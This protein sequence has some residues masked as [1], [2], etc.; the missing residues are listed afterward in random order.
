MNLLISIIIPTYN[1]KDELENTIK[2]VLGQTHQEFELLICDDGSTDGTKGLV[3][4]FS[5]ARIKWISGENS[6]GPAT[7]RNKGINAANA[8]Y[9]AFLDSDDL[10]LPDKLEKQLEALETYQL[11][12]VCTNAKVLK[13]NK[14]LQNTYFRNTKNK[15]IYFEDLLTVNHI[16]CSS[17]LIHKSIVKQVGGFPEEPGFKAIEDYALWLS[18]SMLTDIYYLGEPLVI[19]RDEPEKSIRGEMKESELIK[20]NRIVVE[21]LRRTSYVSSKYIFRFKLLLTLFKRN[22]KRIL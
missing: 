18:S 16:I 15:Y 14:Y 10:W 21:C 9:L 19:Y 12:A 22:I 11:K 4:S 8:E 20:S 3:N 5:D 7:P 2:S 1:R 13:N 17:M 6:G